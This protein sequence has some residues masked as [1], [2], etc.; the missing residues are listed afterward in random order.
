M[1]MESINPATG[2]RIKPVEPWNDA[3][4]NAALDEAARAVTAFIDELS[5]WYVRRSRER[6][7]GNDAAD[8]RHATRTL[9]VCLTDLAKL[10]APFAPFIAEE[11]YRAV[12]A[13][14]DSVHLEE[15][16][17]A[18][19]ESAEAAE[20]LVRMKTLRTLVTQALEQRDRAGVPVRQPLASAMITAPESLGA[21]PEI[22]PIDKANPF[23]D[24]QTNPF[25]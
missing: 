10:M 13:K 17:E 2:E 25:E 19:S 24:I 12:C 11:V 20:R 1:R 22:N 14:K 23:K 15:W 4:V 3:Q 8:R 21:T 5:T 7:K 9:R 16:P 6:F 18:P